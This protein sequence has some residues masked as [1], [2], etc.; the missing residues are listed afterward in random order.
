MLSSAWAGLRRWES[1]AGR[2]VN[3]RIFSAMLTISSL[4]LVVRVVNLGKEMLV[5]SRFG[6]SDTMDAFLMALLF[7]TFAM[8]L[9]AGPLS[10]ALVP[11]FIQ[12]R[13]G[14]G[15]EEASRRLLAGALVVNL[16]L[17][18]I[19]AI[20]AATLVPLALPWLAHGF[21]PEKLAL[22]RRMFFY[23]LPVLIVSG[24]SVTLGTVLNAGE[25]FALTALAPVVRP[26]AI[27]GAV[28]LVSRDE[29]A[30]VVGTGTG[31][32]FELAL[33]I[34]GLKRVGLLILPRWRGLT[35]DLRDV[36]HQ[37]LP[38]FASA[39][40]MGGTDF[41]DQSMA[42]TLPP[43]SVSMLA[44]GNRIVNVL[45]ALG[46]TTISTA[47]LPHFSRLIARQ[48]WA[49]LKRTLRV[50]GWG[51]L[52]LSLVVTAALVGL[53]RTVIEFLLQ[54]GAFSR[55]DTI[56]VSRV[57]AASALQIP[58]YLANVLAVRLII[59]L[60]VNRILIWCA[61]QN[62]IIN[63]VF[64]YALMKWAG[65]AGIALATSVVYLTNLVIVALVARS[66][67]R[68]AIRASGATNA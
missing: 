46:A 10:T 37:Y 65:V 7:P 53:S 17:L 62:F 68:K 38:L 43:G 57:Q 56:V 35:P 27:I 22:T 14:P 54:R 63:I 3:R 30:L 11:K 6:T 29:V 44:Y 19:A 4:T 39:S 61:I 25:R 32:L 67:L 50:Y 52:V 31:F 23:L 45:M 12:M 9:A 15:G 36:L 40:V 20:A 24:I 49:T 16:L 47:V 28:L 66:E 26:M 48:D 64:D 42:A 21:G 55:A 58:F 41:V 1:W 60:K 13:E 18:G 59:A 33:L 8:T 51:L 5:A 2:T 34:H